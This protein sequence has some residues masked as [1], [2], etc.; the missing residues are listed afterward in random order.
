MKKN[1]KKVVDGKFDKEE[2]KDLY[3]IIGQKRKNPFGSQTLEVYKAKIEKMNMSDLHEH[4]I[5]VGLI[6]VHNRKVLLGRLEKE[7]ARQRIKMT[8]SQIEPAV[9]GK[10]AEN[11]FKILNR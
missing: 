9:K 3:D 5:S 6:P 7:F 8:P 2:K 4:A 10:Q 1:T 11:F